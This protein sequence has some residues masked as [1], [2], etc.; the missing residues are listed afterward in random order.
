MIEKRKIRNQIFNYFGKI[1]K[2]IKT[3]FDNIC[4]KTGQYNVPNELFQKRTNRYN[5]VLISWKTVKNNNFTI[6]QLK[7]FSGGVVVEFINN[8]YFNDENYKNP[9][10]C[11]LVKRIGCDEIVS[12]MISIRSE[13][14]SSSSAIQREIF[15]KLISKT[16]IKY[17][18]KNIKITKDN[19]K[20]YIIIR[21]TNIK[22]PLV[23]NDKW[24]GFLYV[25]IKGGQ[26]DTIETHSK[27]VKFQLF[28]PACEFA[29]EDVGLD[30]DLV[31]SFFA[32]MGID[33]VSIS[34]DKL[35]EV[36]SLIKE[37][38]D[39]LK[40]S[41]Y[42]TG[43]LYDYCI[44][45]PSLNIEKK[46]LYDSIQM[47]KINITDFAIDNK[48]DENNIDFSHNEAVNKDVYYWDK[49][50]KCILPPTR[51]TNI[52]WSKHLS[53]MMQ[54]NFTLEEYFKEEQER[55]NRRKK[56]YISRKKLY[57]DKTI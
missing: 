28:N 48:K 32:L 19:Y 49:K 56:L 15:K 55:V 33:R 6:E 57:I 52:F 4:G 24:K 46:C 9:I 13:D 3:K 37:L 10:F 34:P 39:C 50:H 36:N 5:R 43:T 45:H 53:N 8:D 20:K 40:K 22:K 42:D 35:K 12:S 27:C 7:S 31:M 14:G 23:Y 41:E 2:K 25:S 44:K 11:D 54:Q 26:Q 51:P 21:K 29:N 38:S 30:I 47:K 16:S 17:Q 18:G 1:N